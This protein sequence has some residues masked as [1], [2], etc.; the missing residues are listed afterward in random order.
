MARILVVDDEMLNRALLRACFS[1]SGHVIVE[2]S[3]GFE[4]LVAAEDVTPD[5]V[6]LDVM[7][8][9]MDGFECVRQLR[10]LFDADPVP[11]VLVTAL[12]DRA[13]R[14]TG[15]AAG[16]DEL[17]TKPIDREE[18]LVR[19]GNLLALR[20]RSLELRRRNVELA[21]LRRFQDDT[22]AMI[23]HDLKGPLSV[24]HASVDYLLGLDDRDTET[25]ATLADCRQA[26][27]RI[28]RLVGNILEL[29][30][31]EAGRLSLHAVP[32]PIA[33][34]VETV[35]GPRRTGLERRGVQ[36]AI[37]AAVTVE[38]DRDLMTRTLENIV[39]N[40]ARHTP[41]GGL[42]RVWGRA[43]PGGVELR[44]G[45]SGSAIPEPNRA[46]VF[47][48]YT[49]MRDAHGRGSVG[50]G[51]Y[52]CRLAVEAHGGSIW[53]EETPELPTVIALRLPVPVAPRMIA[54]EG[55]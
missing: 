23:V 34:L 53:I 19:A 18:L 36:T 49:Q 31:A 30:H 44:I 32:G 15:L 37:D 45:N 38:V 4:A 43:V 13:A 47:E 6:L 51:L 25:R 33:P 48:K 40:A 16:A 10:A 26:S 5:L 42:I 39:D 28:S 46:L 17:L 1:N 35:L 24:I 41:Q 54:A 22:M 50:L 14:L 2:A 21:E 12:H 55:R 8:P 27:A 20:A 11:I 3:D 7:M 9:G 52:F 29:A